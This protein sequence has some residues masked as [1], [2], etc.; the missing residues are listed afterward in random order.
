MNFRSLVSLSELSSSS[1]SAS[2]AE[3]DRKSDSTSMGCCLGRDGSA[4]KGGRSSG[5]GEARLRC[6][7]LRLGFGWVSGGGDDVISI[8]FFGGFEE[9][10]SKMLL[11]GA[12]TS[13]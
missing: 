5:E 10:F 1:S 2:D 12:F 6:T 7:S 9:Y 3:S 4:W 13:R 11:C 8:A